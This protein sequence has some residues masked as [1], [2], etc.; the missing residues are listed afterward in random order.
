MKM[1]RSQG[2]IRCS[3][4]LIVVIS[5]G[6]LQGCNRDPNVKKAKYLKSGENYA[7]Q[8]KQHVMKGPRRGNRE[9]WRVDH[10]RA[11]FLSIG[12][13]DLQ[14]QAAHP[15]RCIRRIRIGSADVETAQRR[16]LGSQHSAPTPV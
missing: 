9:E 12:R 5:A 7:A 8:G 4:L 3:A 10:G 11:P 6:L 16:M 15:Y 1:L 13:R 14:S 2:T